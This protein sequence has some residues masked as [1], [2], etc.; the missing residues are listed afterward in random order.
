[1]KATEQTQQTTNHNNTTM[2]YKQPHKTKQKIKNKTT[3]KQHK[4]KNTR[5]TNTTNQ[6]QLNTLKTTYVKTRNT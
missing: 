6:P 2:K 5:H 1:M 4:I 3:L